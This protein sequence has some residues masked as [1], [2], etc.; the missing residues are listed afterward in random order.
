MGHEEI[1]SLSEI[2]LP[3][4]KERSKMKFFLL[5]SEVDNKPLK[6]LLS[7]KPQQTRWNQQKNLLFILVPSVLQKWK[8]Y[9][10]PWKKKSL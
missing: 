7:R 1:V 9:N 10:L 8:H 3:W 2:Q 6:I 4:I 5:E